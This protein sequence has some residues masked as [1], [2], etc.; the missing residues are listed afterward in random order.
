MKVGDRGRVGS[1]RR[2]VLDGGGLPHARGDGR[3]LLTAAKQ[4]L[5]I[6]RGV[7]G[8]PAPPA[9]RRFAPPGRP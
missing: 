4:L 7:P 2:E 1:D 6:A 8:A 3:E 9:R 5:I